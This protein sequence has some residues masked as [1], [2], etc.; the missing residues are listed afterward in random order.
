M[1]NGDTFIDHTNCMFYFLDVPIGALNS[2]SF[3]FP[4]VTIYKCE[5]LGSHAGRADCSLCQT[6]DVKYGCVWCMSQCSFVDQC[7]ETPM[8]ACPP[9][10]IDYV[11]NW[12][13][14]LFYSNVSTIS[15]F[16]IHPISGPVEGGTLVSIE[17]SNLGSSF[18]EIKDRVS[19]GGIP[20]VPIEYN[21]SIRVICRTGPSLI[22]PQSALVVIGNRAGVTRAQEKFQYKVSELSW[23]KSPI[24]M[25]KKFNT[26]QNCFQKQA[27]SS[28]T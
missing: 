2:F 12:S 24:F 17:G 11:W 26:N 9:P 18:D 4:I 7:S 15:I 14:I 27:N 23:K 20:C 8:N 5:F 21:V 13:V 28:I 22:G 10:R 19:I 25:K 16:Q 1:W 6:R 3:G